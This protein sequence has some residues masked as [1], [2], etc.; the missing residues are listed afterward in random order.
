MPKTMV[1]AKTQRRQGSNNQ[2]SLFA[3]LARE[4]FLEHALSNI[5]KQPKI[6]NPKSG[7][8]RAAQDKKLWG[9]RFTSA[10]AG[11]IEA[12]TASINVDSRLYRHDIA[13]SIAHA[14]MLARQH[15]I[16]SRDAEKI[17]RGLK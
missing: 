5:L 1:R 12:F 7:R 16:P 4:I 2:K 17:V 14:R 3:S 6:Q 8:R 11:S 13:G 10:T 15:I 9:G